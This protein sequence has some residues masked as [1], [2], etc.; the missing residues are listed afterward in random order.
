M[1]VNK[2]ILILESKIESS[3]E[4]VNCLRGG[5]YDTDLVSDFEIAIQIMENKSVDL[6]VIETLSPHYDGFDICKKIISN[7]DLSNFPIILMNEEGSEL[8]RVLALELGALDFIKKPFNPRELLLRVRN[9]LT[10]KTSEI[11]KTQEQI[12]QI[13]KL[14]IDPEKR[15]VKIGSEMVKLANMEFNLL[16]YLARR[17]GKL[18]PRIKIL[19]N[20][21]G[22]S[23]NANSRTVDTHIRRIRG[24]IGIMGTRLETVRGFG[25]RFR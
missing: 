23:N 12:I 11:K 6:A 24:K 13:D 25:Y 7:E 3:A 19:Q 10:A 16:L 1:K 14:V 20:V 4:V 21:W 15:R 8:D 9:I 5:G 17:Y 2:K 22:Y 18:Q